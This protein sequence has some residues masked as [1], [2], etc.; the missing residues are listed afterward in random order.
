[1][2]QIIEFFK[3]LINPSWI[4]EHGG[5]YLL[6]AIIFAET[7]L[8]VGFFLPGDSLLFVAGIYSK[9]LCS[10][11]FDLPFLLIMV[12]V[13]IAGVL[14]NLV[15]FWF[16]KKSGPLLFKKQDTF[17]FKKKHLHQAHEFFVKYG[18]GAIFFARFLPIIRTFAPIVAG[19]VEMDTKKFM[20]YNIIGSFAWV[21]SMMLGGH[22]LDK[23]YP[24]LKEHL[25]VIILII[26][27]ITTL[28]VIIKIVFGKVKNHHPSSH[29]Q[30]AVEKTDS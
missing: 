18:G 11:F 29:Q 26:V 7:G 21:F 3:H 12:M 14:G 8:F 2:D 1:M 22:Y 30:D 17:F 10:S 23:M 15:G 16:G 27:L 4:I 20:V 9:E 6:L 25:E 13:A 24:G 5:L 28:P 19:I